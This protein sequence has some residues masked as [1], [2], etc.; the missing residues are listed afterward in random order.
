MSEDIYIS[1]VT[2]GGNLEKLSKDKLSD[3]LEEFFKTLM[4]AVD[5]S[6]NHNASTGEYVKM[7]TGAP[8]KTVTLPAVVAGKTV[9]I[10]VMKVDSGGGAVTVDTAGAETING[11][12][13]DTLSSQYD[14]NKYISNDGGD[15]FIW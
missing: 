2:N 12:A 13:T 3:K 1:T 4:P 9:V 14:K 15:Y 5:V 6:A 7:T 11:S 8:G 10:C